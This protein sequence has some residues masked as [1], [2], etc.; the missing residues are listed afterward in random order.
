VS[1]QEPAEESTGTRP[2]GPR[3]GLGERLRSV[4]AQP[5]YRFATFFLLYLV[6]IAVGYPRL[7][8]RLGPLLEVAERFTAQVVYATMSPFSSEVRLVDHQWIFNG[9]FPVVIIEEC[10]GLYEAL[11]LGAALL[12]FPTTWTKAL[13]GF[14]IGFPMI[15]AMNIMRICLLLV[16]GRYMGSWFD[17]LHVYFWQV[18]MIAMVAST[19]LF[20]VIWVVRGDYGA[21]EATR[22]QE[23]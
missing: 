4:W 11:L 21:A 12:A 9:Q 23:S 2:P 14:A 13:L 18:P 20:W 6:L 19:W 22:G 15:Y 5:T 16:T 8:M 3:A 1:R 17:L 7:R 10:T